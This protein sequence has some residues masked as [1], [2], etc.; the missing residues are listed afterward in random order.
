MKKIIIIFTLII[1]FIN[2]NISVFCN[3]SYI[4][5]KLNK[6]IENDIESK[7][8]IAYVDHNL[9]NIDDINIKES[10]IERVV[11][12]NETKLNF[13]QLEFDKMYKKTLE[14]CKQNKI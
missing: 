2:I 6:F 9:V 8:I 13:Y 10:I 5:N 11:D 12:Y 3:D 4:N 1:I 7:Y 14:I